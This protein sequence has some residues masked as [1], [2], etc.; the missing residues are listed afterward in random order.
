MTKYKQLILDRI[1]LLKGQALTDVV[2][3]EDVIGVCFE[4]VR[5]YAQCLIRLV[6]RSKILFTRCDY[7]YKNPKNR[8][9]NN[10]LVNGKR[11]RDELLG[12]RVVAASVGNLG[13]VVIRL[14]N[15][16]R[17]EIFLS[18][19]KENFC[20]SSEAYRIETEA[21]C[22]VVYDGKRTQVFTEEETGKETGGIQ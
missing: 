17:I 5:I 15:G 6:K 9:E 10:L 12:L 8:D 4:T 18:C 19:G 3:C 7:F 1:T 20:G 13:D 2:F 11:H 21:S 16:Y 22:L 14:E